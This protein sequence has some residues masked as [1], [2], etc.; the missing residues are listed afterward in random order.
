MIRS[1][2]AILAGIVTLTIT[3]FAIEAA[4]DPL[5][6][7][8]F[9]HALPNRAAISHSLPATI[10]LLAYTSLMRRSR[11]LRYG[12]AQRDDLRAPFS[13]YGRGPGRAHCLGDDVAVGSQR[14][15]LAQLDW[16]ARLHLPAAWCGGL[17]RAKL[18]RQEK[19]LISRSS[20]RATA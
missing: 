19:R 4:A 8:L 14:S 13:A 17:L 2:L 20:R 5:M 6:M 3:S 16:R 15:A 1:V 9:P 12:M 18:A 11:R 10:F 7:R